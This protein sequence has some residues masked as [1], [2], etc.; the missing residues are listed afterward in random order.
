MRLI[1][2]NTLNKP[3]HPFKI[4]ATDTTM[5]DWEFF[6]RETASVGGNIT[7]VILEETTLV[8]CFGV[9]TLIDNP[10]EAF[11]GHNRPNGEFIVHLKGFTKPKHIN[12]DFYMKYTLLLERT[13]S[14]GVVG[15]EEVSF[16]SGWF[17]DVS[18]IRDIAVIKPCINIE[19]PNNKDFEGRFLG[20]YDGVNDFQKILI[21]RILCYV[22]LPQVYL[23][24][25]F[26][27]LEG[28]EYEFTKKAN[29]ILK[30]NQKTR[31]SFNSEDIGE[32]YV[33]EVRNI[34]GFGRILCKVSGKEMLVNLNDVNISV[35]EKDWRNKYFTVEANAED[36]SYRL[37]SCDTKCFFGGINC[38]PPRIE[39]FEPVMRTTTANES[40]TLPMTV[41]A[42]VTIDWGD[43]TT[44]TQSAPFT[45]VYTLPGDYHIKVKT[46]PALEITNFSFNNAGDKLK[47]V[48]IR[49][50]GDCRFGTGGG[51]F[52]GCAN[53]ATIT[54]PDTPKELNTLFRFFAGCQAL[55]NVTNIANWDTSLVTNMQD[56]FN[57]CVLFNQD[58]ST[59]NTSL[60]T[61]M[62]RM[63][64]N[65]FSYNQPTIF[66]TSNVTNMSEMFRNTRNFN[67][68]IG[69]DTINVTTMQGMFRDAFAFNGIFSNFNTINVVDMSNMF[70]DA[71]VFN[72]NCNFDTRNV[73]TMSFM[74]SN[75]L[76]FNS[77]VSS[78]DTSKV[79][80]MSYMFNWTPVFNQ[81]V[82]NFNT[83]N[84]INFDSMF[85]HAFAF[86]QPVPFNTSNATNMRRMFS[87][88]TVF[89]QSVAGFDTRKVTTMEDMFS[90]CGINQPI[91]F[92]IPALTNF[93]FA[94]NGSG[95]SVSNVDN[96]W[97]HFASQLPNL[98]SNVNASNQK[99]PSS[100]S[101]A[102]R[103]S[104]IAQKSWVF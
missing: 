1:K 13:G 62:E 86:N 71:R 18:C 49:N 99:T 74:F 56:T 47:I 63:F 38:K 30:A 37:K 64:V 52:W 2:Q 84:V 67:Q 46:T 75:A 59:W 28:Y 7:K 91:T 70:N 98:Q 43:G 89:N 6:Y 50:W 9:E 33:N 20:L 55:S 82:S 77:S 101:N 73:T 22:Y 96:M 29:R 23:N 58:I 45:K 39:T 3:C 100:A 14:G 80:D 10:I 68:N 34:L 15:T 61:T 16:V 93:R 51:N 11:V 32:N 95:L 4:S 57:S 5:L 12:N 41:T 78:F 36:E 66:N 69:F 35:K 42:P 24:G 103:N 8:D 72:Q 17:K 60:V 97:I 94:T 31:Y 27:Y 40:I 19:I 53:L 102:A 83:I 87:N 65:C 25:G 21:D 81:T 92:N 85:F 48:G 104:L 79:T 44:T 76:V 54:A 88:S 90:Y 26:P